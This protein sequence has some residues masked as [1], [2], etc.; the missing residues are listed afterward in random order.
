VSYLRF[1][2]VIRRT[3]LSRMTIWRL[4]RQGEFPNRRQLAKNC[5]GWVEEE[6]AGWMKSRPKAQPDTRELS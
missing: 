4:E 3:G 6:V 5:V 2:E 1:N